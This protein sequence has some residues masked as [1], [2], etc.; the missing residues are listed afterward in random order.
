M[1][2]QDAKVIADFLLA[3]GDQE[4]ALTTRVFQAVPAGRLDYRPDGLSKTALGLLRHITLEDEWILDA[5]ATGAFGPLPDDSDACGILTPADATTRYQERIPAAATR[6]RALSGDELLREVDLF[7]M[8]KMPAVAFLSLMQRHSAHHRGQ[9][10]SYL[11]A[12]GGKVPE[13]YGPTADT[14]AATA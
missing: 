6:V 10:S 14:V 8:V 12:M 5:V 2:P 1:K 11:R 4:M 7:G 13:I 3:Q 9:L